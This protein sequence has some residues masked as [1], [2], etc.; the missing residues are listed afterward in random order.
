MGIYRRTTRTLEL[1]PENDSKFRN[2]P[3]SLRPDVPPES[4]FLRYELRFGHPWNRVKTVV[5][6]YIGTCL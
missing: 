5:V 3:S 6:G 1:V 4:R 2:I